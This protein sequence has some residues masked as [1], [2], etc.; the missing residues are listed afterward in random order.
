MAGVILM[1]LM[2]ACYIVRDQV[3]FTLA[4]SWTRELGV[5]SGYTTH[6]NPTECPDATCIVAMEQ[7]PVAARATSFA[8]VSHNE[9]LVNCRTRVGDRQVGTRRGRVGDEST[10]CVCVRAVKEAVASEKVG[11]RYR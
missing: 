10:S 2:G 11:V 9:R 3:T 8:V 6:S 5:T 7:R 1:S 4:I